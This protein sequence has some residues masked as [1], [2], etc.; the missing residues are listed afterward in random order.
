MNHTTRG[1]ALGTLMATAALLT[2]PSANAVDHNMES[3]GVVDT[4][5]GRLAD[6]L[7]TA[8]G[9]AD[10]AFA[11]TLTVAG[12]ASPI[13]MTLAPQTFGEAIPNGFVRAEFSHPAI[14]DDA[15]TSA[16]TLLEDQ[17]GRSLIRFVTPWGSTLATAG[18]GDAMSRVTELT[19]D[20]TSRGVTYQYTLTRP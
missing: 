15:V 20:V 5:G 11:G 4:C 3:A 1:L 19:G 16:P 10:T 7:A 9:T 8:E 13:A 17:Y 14:S 12:G 2:V 18:C 6:Y